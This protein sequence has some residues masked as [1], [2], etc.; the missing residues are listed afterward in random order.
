MKFGE[1]VNKIDEASNSLEAKGLTHLAYELDCIANT[2]E[3][4][5]STKDA[6]DVPR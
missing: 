5:A 3:K 4:K 1:L 2:L 6:K